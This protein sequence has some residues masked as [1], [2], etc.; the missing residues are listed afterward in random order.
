MS[1]NISLITFASSLGRWIDR[2][3]SRL[4]PLLITIV[5]NRC[6]VIAACFCWF[7]VV[8]NRNPNL[9]K[10]LISNEGALDQETSDAGDVAGGLSSDL[11]RTALFVLVLMLGISERLSRSANLISIERD[12]VPT[13]APPSLE[14]DPTANFSLTHLNAVMSRID[15]I[16]KLFAPISISLFV[17]GVKS[18]R[19]GIVAVAGLSVLSWGMEFWSAKRVWNSNSRLNQP[20][21]LNVINLDHP[22]ELQNGGPL[23]AGKDSS[24]RTFL[25]RMREDIHRLLLSTFNVIYVALS[26]YV[27]SLKEYFAT[28]VWVPSIAKSMLDFSVLSYSGTLDVF[29]LHAGFSLNTITLAAALGSLFE[30]S[31]TFLMPWGV[32]IL[33]V[34]RGESHPMIESP[35]G[36]DGGRLLVGE[37]EDEENDDGEDKE[38]LENDIITGVIR[39]GLWGLFEMLLALTPAVLAIW[40]F[41]DDLPSDSKESLGPSSGTTEPAQPLRLHPLVVGT[42]LFFVAASRLGRC[43]FPLAI[44]Q[45]SQARVSPTQWSSF[46]G[47]EM[48]FVSLFSLGHWIAAAIWSRP[49]QFQW[50]ALASLIAVALSLALYS[51]WVF[52]ERRHLIHWDKFCAMLKFPT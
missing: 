47:T 20:K 46:A 50:L 22:D 29:L 38:H 1:I 39:V 31:S 35:H 3:E 11:G 15:L 42:I 7:F 51:F 32:R 21:R 10:R 33:S 24:L 16:C 9:T 49:Y 41:V 26:D 12:W 27:L 4:R 23:N 43:T 48:S 34:P 37:D 5:A 40:Q 25:P 17:S 2:S 30:L 13:L 19:I 36:E 18:V 6:S 14:D 52:R 45:L 8:G 28:N 44:Q